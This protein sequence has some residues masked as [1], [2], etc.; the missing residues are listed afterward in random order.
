MSKTLPK[1]ARD[2][3]TQYSKPL[4]RPNWKKKPRLRFSVF[5]S[6]L[7]KHKYCIVI[8]IVI[9]RHINNN[10]ST[11]TILQQY[12]NN[13]SYYKMNS[14]NS[15]SKHFNIEVYTLQTIICYGI[16]N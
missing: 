7:I 10:N 15:L 16:Y 13:L 1:R 11:L 8:D 9:Y 5:Y 4:T 2:L 12:V 3:I 6:N 14:L